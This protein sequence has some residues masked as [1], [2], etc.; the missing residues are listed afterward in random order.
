MALSSPGAYA[1]YVSAGEWRR[2]RHLDLLN[3]HVVEAAT[4]RIS[5]LIVS[6]PPRYGKSE[7]ISRYTP[8]WFLSVYPQKNVILTSYEA[9]FASEWGHK[10]KLLYDAHAPVLSGTRVDP[11]SGRRDRWDIVDASGSQTGGGM[12]TAGSDGPLTGK[13]ADLLVIDDPVKNAEEANSPRRREKVWEWF[14][15]TVDSRLESGAAIILVQT[16]WNVDDLAGQLGSRLMTGRYGTS[17]Y[18]I[19][20]FP[21]LAIMGQLD[22]LGRRPGECLWPWKFSQKEAE[23]KRA[24]KTLY[25]WS[26]MHQGQPTIRSGTTFERDWFRIVDNQPR[27]TVARCR[28]WDMAATEG[29]GDYTVGTLMSKIADGRYCIEDVV[30]GQWS[31]K[32]VKGKVKQTAIQDGADVTVVMEQEPGSGGKTQV[33]LYRTAL[34]GFKFEAVS[35][36]IKKE[37][38]WD[39]FADEAALGNMMVLNREWLRDFLHELERVPNP[40]GYDDQTDSAS[41]AFK[42]LVEVPDTYEPFFI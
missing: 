3:R 13:G 42:F 14:E 32:K 10:A 36:R 4:G 18:K 30:R 25:W 11:D 16:R 6:M 2:A 19:I 37:L 26:C 1:H 21:E 40:S 17:P 27:Q 39:S 22:P 23:E 20:N 9:D 31:S 8:A 29:G 5:I 41:G 34:I 12:R 24:K 33:E 35:S 15:S 7:L 28:F 38:T